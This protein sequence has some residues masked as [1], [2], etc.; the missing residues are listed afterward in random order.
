M[1]GL[2]PFVVVM[3]VLGLAACG[4]HG[5]SPPAGSPSQSHSPSGRPSST[6]APTEADPAARTA[7]ELRRLDRAVAGRRTPPERV[8]RAGRRQQLVLRSLGGSPGLAR[9]VLTRLPAPLRARTRAT[10]RAGHLLRSMYSARSDALPHR[11]PAW[12]IERPA[13]ARLLLGAYHQAER[14]YGVSWSYLA[15]INMIESDFGRVHG[16][17][18]AGARGPMQFIPATWRAY[19]AGGDIDDPHDAV[20]GAARLL[21]ANGF[22]RTP[23]AALRHYNDS[24][25]YARAVTLLADVM[26]RDPPQFLGFRQWRVFYLTARGSVLLPVG[27]DERHGVALGHWLA[28]HPHALVLR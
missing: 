15:A 9:R 11:L 21:A 10:L 17:S 6:A 26:H 25:P 2:R 19:G 16:L 23:L 27:Y 3:V 8:A 4:G 13:P 28:R 24:A 20:L 1:T 7:R 12:R 14:R 22:S 5:S 18:S